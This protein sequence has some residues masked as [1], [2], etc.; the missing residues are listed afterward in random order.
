MSPKQLGISQEKYLNMYI[1]SL[2]KKKAGSLERL[3]AI[4]NTVRR[5]GNPI[6]TKSITFLKRKQLVN[7]LYN[8]EFTEEVKIEEN[9]N[10]E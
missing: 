9:E 6:D 10:E 8:Y 3:S 2:R 7:G 5:P 1:S 4:T